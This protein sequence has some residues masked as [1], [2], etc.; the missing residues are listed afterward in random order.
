ML[1]RLIL[2]CWILLASV[3]VTQ[4]VAAQG[5]I[6]PQPIAYGQKVTGTISEQAFFNSWQ[7]DAN[8]HD[9]IYVRM[10]GAD[11]LRPL[12]GLLDSGGTLVM[13][14]ANGIA[15]DSVDLTYDVPAAGK[16]II[17]ATRV[18][19][20]FGTTTG[21][22]SLSLDNINP[23]PT[24]NPAYQDVTFQCGSFDATA[25]ATIRFSREDSDNGAYS[26][27]IYG[28][29]GF[30]PVIRVQSG[31]SDE[32]I[33]D[34]ADALND[35]VT[36]P[37]ERPLT[38]T[39]ADLS[40][41][42]QYVLNSQNTPDP[43]SITITIGSAQDTPGR[44]L[45]VLGGF[46]IEPST[47]TDSIEVRL[48]P[49][50]AQGSDPLSFYMIGVNN[51]LDPTVLTDMGRCDDAGRRGCEDLPS[52]DRAGVIFNSGIQ[53]VGDR[54]DSGALISDT[55]THLLQLLSFS[56]TTHGEYAIFLIGTLSPAPS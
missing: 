51:R 15:N 46:N 42:A 48:A 9:R 18:D 23:P 47:D 54:F 25:T 16:Y 36:L 29:D 17:V 31:D 35:V 10:T 43:A 50:P 30:Q 7:V 52:F 37:G 39:R 26:L 22:Y 14:S 40:H 11:G 5:N 38:I 8:I 6:P 44:Y 53:V 1:R 19:N 12:I 3:V 32:C 55:Q 4:S 2:L 49:R 45:A 28:I 21:S 13:H 24:P 56:G 41:T 20:Q 33:T 27:R 34:P